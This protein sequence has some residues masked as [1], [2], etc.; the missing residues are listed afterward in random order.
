MADNASPAGSGRAR[1]APL[2]S[3]L[4][5]VPAACVSYVVGA[6]SGT[7][8][9]ACDDAMTHR[10]DAGFDTAFAVLR[11][12]L[13]LGIAVLAAAW[14]LP[15][16]RHGGTRWALSVLAPVCVLVGDTVFAALMD[17]P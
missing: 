9:D 16:R 13:G 12:G 14:A 4:L 11:T 1:L 8:C 17:W 15:W 5:T 6:L 10:F 2:V 3:T 7:A